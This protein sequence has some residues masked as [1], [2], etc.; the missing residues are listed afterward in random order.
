MAKI[1]AISG[2]MDSVAMLDVMAR[3]GL[4]GLI[5]AHYNHGIRLDSDMDEEFVRC[6]AEKYG[7]EFVGD[8][9]FL[10][11]GASE[12]LARKKRYEF[13]NKIADDNEAVVCTAHHMDDVVETV[14]INL[15]RG[16]G[17][18][19]L[20][21]LDDEKLERP[22]LGWT[23]NDIRRYV[24]EKKLVYREDSTNSSPDYLRNRVRLKLDECGDVKKKV[25]KLFER[26]KL[27]KFEIDKLTEGFLNEDGV[28]EREWF[29]KMDDAVATEILRAAL[30]K[31][32]KSATIPQRRLLLRA[33][34]EFKPGKKLNLLKD[35]EIKF[36]KDKFVL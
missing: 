22:L 32:G 18:R 3:A 23:K 14:V 10:G 8:R 15:V 31:V 17:W 25:Y 2:G 9:G 7:L 24:V 5:V 6:L 11:A 34:R 26:Q 13:L 4:E 36:T 29:S 21:P 28:Y 27:L 33:I 1:L 35:Y 16:T 20:V 30:R 12:E 19:G